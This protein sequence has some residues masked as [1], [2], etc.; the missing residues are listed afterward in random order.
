MMKDR[1]RRTIALPKRFYAA[2]KIDEL[3][4]KLRHSIRPE[5]QEEKENCDPFL[6]FGIGIH[7][8]VRMNSRFTCLFLVLMILAS[9]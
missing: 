4:E 9:L 1:T 7:N 3:F 6:Y 2:E 5:E 8:F